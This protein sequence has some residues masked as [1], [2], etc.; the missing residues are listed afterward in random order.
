MKKHIN[1]MSRYFWKRDLGLLLVRVALG[2]LFLAHGWSKVGN[3]SGTEGMFVHMGFPMWVGVFIAW[4]EVIG[5]IALILGIATRVFAV[6]FGIEMLVAVLI[7]PLS[8][9]IG[10]TELLLAVASFGIALAGS[11][12]F[13]FY[14]MECGNCGGMLCDKESGTC[15]PR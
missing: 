14:A 1:A 2:I 13:S 3:L 10:G 9:A 6:A 7:S 4:F 11:G 12:R 5:G 15:V 8:R